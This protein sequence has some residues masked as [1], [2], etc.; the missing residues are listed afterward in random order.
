MLPSSKVDQTFPQKG[1]EYVYP[2]CGP[3]SCM[4]LPNL[5]GVAMVFQGMF[6]KDFGEK[7]ENLKEEEVK[8]VK[9]EIERES[10]SRA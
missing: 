2:P 6:R 1:L 4:L 10:V 9:E 8:D 7:T 3:F 5:E